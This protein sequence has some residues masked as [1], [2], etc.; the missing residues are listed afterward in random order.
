MVSLIGR[1]AHSPSIRRVIHGAAFILAWLAVVVL[2]AMAEPTF[3]VTLD[4]DTINLGES[5]TLSLVFDDCQPS[6]FP[7]LPQ[8]AGLRF[9]GV[10]QSESQQLIN[11]SFSSSLRYTMELQASHIGE[12]EIPAI[13]A[14]VGG[15]KMTSHPLKLKVV[16]ANAHR[17][18]GQP[19]TAFVRLIPSAT[20][21]YLGQV[22]PIEIQC[23]CLDNVRLSQGPQLNT[24][25]FIVGAI[26]NNHDQSKRRVGNS[27][28]NWLNFHAPVT[29]TR[30]GRQKLGPATWSLTEFQG[31][32][33]FGMTNPRQ[34]DVTSDTPEINVLAIPTNGRP[35]SFHGAIGQ[36]ALVEYSCGPTNVGVGDPVTLKIRIS[37]T[38]SWDSVTVP[39]NEQ[40]WRE[41]KTY[42]PNSKL[43]T[44][45]PMQIQGSKYFEEVI[46]PMNAEIKE[47]PAFSFSY[48][49]PGAGTFRTLSAP[50]IALTVHPTAATPKPTF[51]N[52]AAPAE[53]AQAQN[54]DIVHIK[55]AAGSISA[56]RPP[57]V[58]QP[59]FL[60]LQLA[61]P[62]IWVGALLCRRH[63]D[64]LA[65]SPRL[66][67]RRAVARL[68]EEGYND[69]AAQAAANDADK[70]HATVLRLLQEQLGER[71]DL[72][73]PAITEAVLDDVNGLSES[74]R[75]LAR[76]LF[77]ACN[78]YRY[79][80]EHTSQGMA[81]LIPKVKSA[82]AALRKIP[83]IGGS[84]GRSALQT[85]SVIVLLLTVA[86]VAS[87]ESA[88]DVFLQA[89]KLYEQGKYA[90]A[91]AAYEGLLRSGKISPAIYFNAGNAAFKSGE[92][93]RAIC[94]YRRAEALAPRDPDIRANLEIARTKAG[95]SNAAIPGSR[96]TRWVGRLTVDE[97]TLAASAVA[98]LFFLTLAA[99]QI[100]PAFAKSSG[101]ASGVLAAAAVWCLICLGFSISQRL[102]ERSSVVVVPEAVVRRGPMDVS[103]SAFTAHD[104]T[105]LTVL[106]QNG[107]WLQVTDASHQIG[108]LQQKDVALIP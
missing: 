60:S 72:P 94:D 49:D 40:D 11:G 85:T 31:Q 67:R 5:T 46:T 18:S 103:Q 36:F 79:T 32:N 90:Q 7:K 87:A 68:V 58:M 69:L 93:G 13:V 3:E 44:T 25:N 12:Y 76:D 17:A 22:M 63:K 30:V 66:R 65:N 27:M 52:S 8:V 105:E 39:I 37:G 92:L 102:V 101:G 97:W 41:F 96:W 2:P 108:W 14:D 29:A 20:N 91:S 104:G 28:Y 98:A 59:V 35:A 53:E 107:D 10:S 64:K 9:G 23:Y 42:P 70:F 83:E 89:N 56:A 57:L 61:P 1:K 26:P 62:L 82:L 99:R 50:Q 51:V 48:F 45:D 84:S 34:L 80:P 95:A 16:Q 81:S 54:K 47:L 71:L 6:A 88:D 100:F 73:A 15:K 74:D 43:E 78:Q 19:D 24:D 4:P 75:T 106:S 33:F 86:G 55:P 38:G 21:V 77:H